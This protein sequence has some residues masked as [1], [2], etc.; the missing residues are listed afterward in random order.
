[1]KPFLKWAGNKYAI[2]QRIKAVLPAGNRLI[3][4]FTGSAAV[5][6]NTEFS[7]AIL[8]DINLD[9]INLYRFLKVE[10]DTFIQYCWTFFQPDTNQAE[11]YYEFRELFNNTD[12]ARLK[13]A[14]FL[15]FNRHGYNGLCRYNN[16]GEFNVPFGKYA[17]PYFPLDEM[18]TFHQKI[19]GAELLHQDFISTMQMA[20]PGDVV[21]CDPPYVPLTATAN[22]TGYATGGFGLESQEK[23]AE[24]ARQ[25]AHNGVHVIISNH[26]TSYTQTVYESAQIISF[27]VRRFISCKGESRGQANEMLALF[28]NSRFVE[29]TLAG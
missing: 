14:L 9:L 12:D 6:L 1:M 29:N 20:R 24:M 8:S 26:D 28:G 16:K 13:A 11:R 3:E 7:E 5:F 15:Y 19:Q 25:L 10:G 4:P 18:R 17:K 23:L 2:I 22:F 27:Q 21:Y